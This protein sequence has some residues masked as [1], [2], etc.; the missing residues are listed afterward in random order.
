MGNNTEILEK[1]MVSIT[2]PK[3]QQFNPLFIILLT[4]I[5]VGMFSLLNSKGREPSAPRKIGIGMIIAGLAF[6]ILIIP[7]IGLPAPSEIG[8]AVSDKL[9]SPNWLISTY[10]VL[11]ISELFLSPMGISFVSKV[12]PPQY[13]GLMQGGWLAATAIGNYLVGV[14]G[15][16]WDRVPLF[17]LWSILLVCCLLSATFIF[18]ILNRLERA[19]E[20]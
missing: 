14:I 11:T 4:P 12:A 5:F 6:I 19:T 1:G 18:S 2:P 15:L 16:F 10:F 3:F 17:V 20:S 7:S 13:K 9:V 8:G